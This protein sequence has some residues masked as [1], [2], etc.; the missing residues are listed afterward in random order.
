MLNAQWFHQLMQFESLLLDTKLFASWHDAFAVE[1]YPRS[2][3]NRKTEENRHYC[4][5]NDDM[6]ID[7]FRFG[8][9][10]RGRIWYVGIDWNDRHFKTVE[11]SPAAR[12]MGDVVSE[13][14]FA[15]NPFLRMRVE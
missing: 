5:C 12:R 9:E 14:K 6:C 11:R 4:Y 3:N 15:G 1:E 10:T 8:L 7:L 2:Q 13:K